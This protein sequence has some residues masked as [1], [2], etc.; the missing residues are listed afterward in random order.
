MYLKLHPYRQISMA[1][2][3]YQKL[4]PHCFGPYKI[5]DKIRAV[6]YKLALPPDSQLHTIFHVSHLK[7]KVGSHAK[8]DTQLPIPSNSPTLEPLSILAR[9]MVRRGNRPAT[10]ILVHW[11][12]FFLDDATWE[13]LFDQQQRFPQFQP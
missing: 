13:Y 11:S 3:Q 9:K 1:D 12:N 7:K 6:A 10:Q 2:K 5:L 4:V 8:M